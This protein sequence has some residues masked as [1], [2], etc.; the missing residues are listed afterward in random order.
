MHQNI[1]RV[2]GNVNPTRYLTQDQ[3]PYT[4]LHYSQ[5]SSGLKICVGYFQSK[6]G[7]EI[8]SLGPPV[9]NV[10]NI[11]VVSRVGW[12]SLILTLYVELV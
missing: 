4:H 3:L 9:C 11:D 5:R 10:Y 2:G 7:R 12:G 1:E 6:G 8:V